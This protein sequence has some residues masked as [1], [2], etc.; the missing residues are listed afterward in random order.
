MKVKKILT[1]KVELEAM[2]LKKKMMMKKEVK[3]NVL[4]ANNNDVYQKSCNSN[5]Y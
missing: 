4:D 2:I 5:Y 1:F 3:D